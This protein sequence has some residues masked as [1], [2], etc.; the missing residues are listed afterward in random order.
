MAVPPTDQNLVNEVFLEYCKNCKD[1]DLF[2]LG[3]YKNLDAGKAPRPQCFLLFASLLNGLWEIQNRCQFNPTTIRAALV[4]CANE[5]KHRPINKS[6]FPMK[7]WSKFMQEQLTVM[8]AHVRDVVENQTV[9]QRALKHLTNQQEA[10]TFR[11]L[12]DKLR[13]R[14][15]GDNDA[16]MLAG[17]TPMTQPSDAMVLGVV[18]VIPRFFCVLKHVRCCF[19]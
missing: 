6:G 11:E 3:V 10:E 15:C 17:K 8:F 4:H 2:E 5:L 16:E 9:M 7:Q 12:I 13:M 19:F 18:I 1:E 14:Y